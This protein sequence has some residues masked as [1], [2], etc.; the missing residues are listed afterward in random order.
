MAAINPPSWAKNAVPTL[1]G[2]RDPRSNELLKSQAIAQED[3]DS[4]MG[5]TEKKSTRPIKAPR[6]KVEPPVATQLNEA[7]P[8]HKS[9]D[10]MT[11]M[12]L[13]A[14]GRTMGI[15]LDRRKG[16]DLLIEELKEV[17]NN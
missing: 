2:W 14:H 6:E 7:P 10:E 3:I 17:V 5:V 12:E 9:L 4:Y 15:E 16:K 13:E 8:N 11:K 1:T